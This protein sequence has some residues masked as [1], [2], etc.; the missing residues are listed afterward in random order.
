VSGIDGAFPDGYRPTNEEHV[1]AMLAA[2]LAAVE[3]LEAALSTSHP[4]ERKPS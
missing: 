1:N 3:R 4:H 2:I